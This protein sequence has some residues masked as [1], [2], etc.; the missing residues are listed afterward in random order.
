[1]NI[2][3]VQGAFLPVP[4]IMG[5]GVEKVWSALT[6]EFVRRGHAVT[7]LSRR[8]PQLPDAETRDGVR[9]VRLP[10]FDSPRGMLRRQ[11]EDFIYSLRAVRALPDA[12][13]LVTNTFWLPLLVRNARHGKLYVHIARYP[14]RQMALYRRADRL[15]AVSCPVADAVRAQVPALADKVRALPNPLSFEQYHVSPQPTAVP[16]VILY[17]GRVHPEKGL[18]LLVRA[19]ARLSVAH[20]LRIVGPWQTEF[21]GGGEA[22]HQQLRSLAAPER[23]SFT[24]PIFQATELNAQFDAATLFVYPS[25]AEKGETFGLA[26]LEAMARSR[27]ALVSDLACFRDFLRDGENGFVF[28][29]RA[30]DPVEEL[31]RSMA[32]LL[33]APEQLAALA[34][35]AYATAKEFALPQVA[36]RYLADFQSLLT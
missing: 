9:H 31:T 27:V 17:V 30:A 34:P 1:M 24:G 33:G 16:P 23:V 36:G 4:P 5:G 11:C 12:D 13:I 18:E 22:Y 28:N 29:H 8:H 35:R 7:H 20:Q 14:K 3:V 6:Q 32:S 15:Q 10:G 2:T 21:G 19:C 25:L 26:P